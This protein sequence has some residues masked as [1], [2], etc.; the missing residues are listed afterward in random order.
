VGSKWASLALQY[1]LSK[2]NT[3]EPCRQGNDSKTWEPCQEGVCDLQTDHLREEV[4]ILPGSRCSLLGNQQGIRP[5][6]WVPGMK[7]KIDPDFLAYLQL[8]RTILRKRSVSRDGRLLYMYLT[9]FEN[10]KTNQAKP[11]QRL[12]CQDLQMS[13]TTLQKVLDELHDKKLIALHQEHRK[14][15]KL[16]V[17]TLI[18]P[19]PDSKS[20]GT[21]NLVPFPSQ[22]YTNSIPSTIPSDGNLA[23]I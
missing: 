5:L 6:F 19:Q 12:I 15:G 18:A 17:Y 4:Q 10:L 22:T 9:T 2:E 11:G 23:S 13:R 20:S 3:G 1:E 7:R 16:N 21:E 14:N 8:V